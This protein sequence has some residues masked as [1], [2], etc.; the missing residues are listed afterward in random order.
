MRA[1][2][3]NISAHISHFG[4]SDLKRNASEYKK[5]PLFASWAALLN[6]GAVQMPLFIMAKYFGLGYHPQVILAGRKI[7]DDMVQY[8]VKK[9]IQKMHI[10]GIDVT[11]STV[12]VLGITFKENCPD[13]RNSKIIDVISELKNWGVNIV[14]ADPWAGPLAVDQAYDIKLG[15]VDSKHQTDSLIVAVGHA[16]YR[17]L[18]PE[19]LRSFCRGATPVL[20]DV[21]SLYDR[22]LLNEQGFPVFRL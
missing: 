10:N 21:K 15:K 8:M 13:I 12:G 3:K 17:D 1:S 7:N 14:V 20:A 9:V 6:T 18:D 16:E 11:K 5:F 2:R 19:T 22:D 4:F